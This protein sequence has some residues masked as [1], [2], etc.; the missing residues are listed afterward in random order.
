MG[1]GT[2]PQTEF[3]RLTVNYGPSRFLWSIM[4]LVDLWGL[5]NPLAKDVTD[6]SVYLTL[7][8]L[9]DILCDIFPFSFVSFRTCKV[10]DRP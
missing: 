9:F 5:A 1:S 3:D 10:K 4:H 2:Q 6:K 8:C 7:Y